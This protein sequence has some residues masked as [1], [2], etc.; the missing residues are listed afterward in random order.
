MFRCRAK[1]VIRKE[2][3]RCK[4]DYDHRRDWHQASRAEYGHREDWDVRWMDKAPHAFPDG[5][6]VE[7]R[8]LE[9]GGYVRR[10]LDL[11]Q[12]ELARVRDDGSIAITHR[13][14]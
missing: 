12:H 6:D 4:L 14:S 10:G 5:E 11:K 3:L 7:A 8:L 2:I 9:M 1:C 13:H